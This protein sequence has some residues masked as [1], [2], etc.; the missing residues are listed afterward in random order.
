MDSQRKKDLIDCINEKI[1]NNNVDG[2]WTNGWKKRLIKENNEYF[3]GL[4]K[5]K[6]SYFI[7]DKYVFTKNPGS[8]LNNN[9][10]IFRGSFGYTSIWASLHSDMDKWDLKDVFQFTKHRDDIL[11]DL[12]KK[13]GCDK[14]MFTN[15]KWFKF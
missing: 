4:K 3:K 14:T 5:K 10:Y 6:E 9:I 12:A 13:Y 11:E 1:K 8:I 2:D 7:E 15:R